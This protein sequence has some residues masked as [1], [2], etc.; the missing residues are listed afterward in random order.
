MNLIANKFEKNSKSLMDL[1][2]KVYRKRQCKIQNAMKYH[3]LKWDPH[4]L[5]IAM[6]FACLGFPI[7]S[8]DEIVGILLS[9]CCVFC[10]VWCGFILFH[11]FYS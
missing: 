1:K 9:L 6:H 4:D 11:E 2:I 10:D 7:L 3:V 8:P 5:G